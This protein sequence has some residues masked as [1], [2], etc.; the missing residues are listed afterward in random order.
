MTTT[1]T[2]E[3]ILH[4]MNS[5][6]FSGMK[7]GIERIREALRLHGNPEAGLKIINVVGTNG[8]GSVTSM[9]AKIL[10][11]SG[12][13]VGMFTSPH[14]VDVR[15]RI[16]INGS[17]IS[18]DDFREMFLEAKSTISDL[19]FFELVTLMAVLYFVREK[20]EYAIFEAGLGGTYDATNFESGIMT[21]VTRIALDHT[22][23]LGNTVEKIAADKCGVVKQGETVVITYANN[24]I[25][26]VIKDSISDK[27]VKLMIADD[28]EFDV[29]LHGKFQK[30]NAGVAVSAA[31]E[32]G[33]DNAVIQQGLKEV[34]W[35]GRVEY[36]DKNVL[37]DC[38]HN[39]SG[40]NALA[41][42]LGGLDYEKLYLV[43]GVSKNK[44]YANMI[45]SLPSHEKLIFTQ[46]TVS[47]RLSIDDIPVGL[48]CEKVRDPLLALER[49]KELAGEKDLVVVCGSIFLIG[50]IKAALMPNLVKNVVA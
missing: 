46:S 9:L 40:I 41:D 6:E 16:Q 23:I 19:T 3:S 27:N 7:L 30:E 18:K 49:A 20:V 43:F 28:S 13:K 12:F 36:I 26:Q 38:A 8:K 35:P 44:D 14:L 4:F 33:I 31:R 45:K 42:Y 11:E 39:P 25:I 2:Y 24:D 34:K 17:M 32:L 5:M 15:E 21:L 50:D 37:V 47:R 48:E 10:E 29:S 22:H 1:V